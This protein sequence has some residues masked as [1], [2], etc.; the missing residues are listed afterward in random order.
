VDER[1]PG[2]SSTGVPLFSLST[3]LEAAVA[4]TSLPDTMPPLGGHDRAVWGDRAFRSIAVAAAVSVL[5]ILAFIALTMTQ[6]A[7]PTLQKT[8]LDFVTS[9]TW[10]P[11]DNGSGSHFG[12]LGYIFGTVVVSLIAL[13][14]AVPVS[15]GIALFAT[16][17]TRS[18]FSGPFVAALDLL[19]AVPSVVFG[20]WGLLVVAPNITGFYGRV[21]DVLGPVP[22]IGSLFGPDAVGKSFMTAGIILALMIVPITSSIMREVLNTVPQAER[23]GALALG[24]TRWEM[25]RGVVVPHSFGGMVGGVMLGLGRAMGETIAVALVVG[26]GAQITAN[27]FKAG[28]AMPAEIVNQWGEA[29]G[30]FRSALVALGVVL[31]LMTIVVNVAARFIVGRAELRMRGQA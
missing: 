1:R 24:A 12:A 4:T 5:A 10:I 8:G 23:D 19:A 9:K 16:E 22:L 29:T 17:V 20:F 25:I 7:W 28:D 13:V 21:H 3:R 18:R 15:F 14:L 31:F 11:N 27:L 2:R 30:D 26:G 6:E